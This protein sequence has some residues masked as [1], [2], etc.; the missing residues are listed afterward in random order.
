MKFSRGE[1]HPCLHYT[2]GFGAWHL[3]RESKS[4]IEGAEVVGMALTLG[5]GEFPSFL[6]IPQRLKTEFLT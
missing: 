4:G 1:C 3:Q 6:Q 2:V 5:P